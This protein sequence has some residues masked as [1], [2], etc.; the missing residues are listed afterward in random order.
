MGLFKTTHIHNHKTEAVP[1]VKEVKITEHRAPTDES[2]RLLNE[3]QEKAERNI[4]AQVRVDE[5]HLKGTIIYFQESL[6]DWK[7]RYALK[8]QLNGREHIMDGDIDKFDLAEIERKAYMGIGNRE[9]F[10]ALHRRFSDLIAEQ[11]MNQSPDFL[12]DASRL[13]SN[14]A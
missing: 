14:G 13:G 1:Y 5:N 11:L 10:E 3:M 2:V 12:R 4:I 6:P 7:Y 9:V 8:F